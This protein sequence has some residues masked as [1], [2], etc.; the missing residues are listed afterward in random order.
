MTAWAALQHAGF[1][2]VLALLSWLA[3]RTMIHVRIMDVPNERSSHERA[4]PRGGGVGIVAAFGVGLAAMWFLAESTRLA[5]PYFLGLAI[6]AFAIAV[7]SLVDDLRQ[8]PLLLRLAAQIVGTGAAL[9][10]GLAL[11]EIW[12]PVLGRVELGWFGYV[13]TA[14]WIVGMTNAMNFMDGLNGLVAGT[15]LVAAAGLS[16]V[17]FLSGSHFAYLAALILA[18]G[19]AGFLP[20]NF[21]RARI[22]MGDVGS[23]FLGFA[24]AVLGLIAAH[25]DA[26]R[27]SFMIVPV[28][29]F[30]FL[31][32]TGFT[33]VRRLLAGERV[34]QAHRGHLYQVLNRAGWSH[35]QVSL[36]HWGFAAVQALA[37]LVLIQLPP[38]AKVLVFI[39]LLALQL[40]HL[41][42]VTRLA[43]QARIGSW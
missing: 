7:V 11:H 38:N 30:A 2:V 15:T 43:R 19:I 33:L 35:A 23:Q 34:T 1:A 4:T 20:H 21:P 12:L 13:L 42:N 9:W 8:T 37:A 32:D 3:T 26:Q 18:A 28:L 27:T 25:F 31:F 22:F 36:L 40:A 39:P 16:A 5:Q 6:G 29:L 17:A 10:F 14:F 24:F 41:A